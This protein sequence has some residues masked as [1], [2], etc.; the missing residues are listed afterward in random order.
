MSPARFLHWLG[1]LL[2]LGLVGC[3]DVHFEP[4]D[5][6]GEIDIY[7]DLFATSVPSS[8]HVVA[9]GYWGAIYV[10]EDGGRS[11]KKSD[12]GTERLLYAVSMANDKAGWAVGQLG[13]I[14]RTEDGGHTWKPQDN[15][16]AAE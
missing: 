10:S 15:P 9:V 2:A 5:Y 14:L 16:K 7:D 6:Q 12:S 1:S 3:H 13:L 11:W 8:K 4:H